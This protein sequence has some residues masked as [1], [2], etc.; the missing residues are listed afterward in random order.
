MRA[1]LL[2]ARTDDVK[3]KKEET[4]ENNKAF[5]S[6]SFLPVSSLVAWDW[7]YRSAECSVLA[8]AKQCD[9]LFIIEQQVKHV[10]YADAS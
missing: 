10:V 2:A 9:V 4:K 1:N 8:C 7:D 6:F 3:N 5:T